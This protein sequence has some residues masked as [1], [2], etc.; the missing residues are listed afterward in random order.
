MRK[1]ETRR[2]LGIERVPVNRGAT[3]KPINQKGE[4]TN[5]VASAKVSEND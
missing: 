3:Q 2:F 5:D 4:I 1:K